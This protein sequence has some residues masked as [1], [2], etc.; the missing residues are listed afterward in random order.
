MDSIRQS[1]TFPTPEPQGLP[2]TR[3]PSCS[4]NSKQE[5][6]SHF[7]MLSTAKTA[8]GIE[9]GPQGYKYRTLYELSPILLDNRHRR[10]TPCVLPRRSCAP[11]EARDLAVRGFSA[12]ALRIAER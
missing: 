10:R 3:L 9:A 7:T 1:E 4:L 5:R 8:G 2:L 11:G 6:A 12:P